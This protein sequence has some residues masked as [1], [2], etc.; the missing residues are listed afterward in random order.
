[1]LLHLTHAFQILEIVGVFHRQTVFRFREIRQ[2]ECSPTFRFLIL[3]GTLAKQIEV[4]VHIHAVDIVGVTVEQT[5]KFHLCGIH[6]LEFVL[7]NQTHIVEALLN[8]IVGGLDLFFRHGYL[9]QIV[10]LEVR[11]VG[12]LNGVALLFSEGGVGSGGTGSGGIGCYVGSGI[13]VV[14]REGVFVSSAPVVFQLAIAP[15][16]LEGC[17]TGIFGGGVVE[18][19]RVVVVEGECCGCILVGIGVGSFGILLREIFFA[20]GIFGFLFFFFL[21]VVDNFFN[22]LFALIERHFRKAQ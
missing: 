14:E 2:D 21:Q 17:F 20:C 9:L 11:V 1:M 16:L 19:P 18:I 13:V 22:H 3:P 5:R 4:V 10:F 12:A 15:L 8:H 7:Q 6:I